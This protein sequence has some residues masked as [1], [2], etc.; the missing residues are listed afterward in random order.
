MYLSVP[1]FGFSAAFGGVRVLVAN[2]MDRPA[3]AWRVRLIES[4]CRPVFEFGWA[5]DVSLPVWAAVA[6]G[7]CRGVAVIAAHGGE[8]ETYPWAV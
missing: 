3:S 6:G 8:E 7:I 1:H 2:S 4:S 5:W